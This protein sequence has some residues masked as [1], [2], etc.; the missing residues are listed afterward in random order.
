MIILSRVRTLEYLDDRNVDDEEKQDAIE[1]FPLTE[2]G[3]NVTAQIMSA[4]RLCPL[5]S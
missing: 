1:M 4:C 3:K 2:S 5:K